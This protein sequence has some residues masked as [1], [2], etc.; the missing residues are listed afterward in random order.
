MKVLRTEE[1]H[2]KRLKR[3]SPLPDCLIKY[4]SPLLL[5]R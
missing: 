4:F 5:F 1:H 2:K 3:L